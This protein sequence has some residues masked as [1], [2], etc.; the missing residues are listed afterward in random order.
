MEH[1]PLDR[2]I[3]ERLVSAITSVTIELALAAL[4]S[5]E[6]RDQFGAQW[7]VRIE[8]ARYEADLAERPSLLQIASSQASGGCVCG[9]AQSWWC[10]TSP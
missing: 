5:P 2:S 8:R 7:R 4:T 3:T 1:G 10:A 6:Q 9:L